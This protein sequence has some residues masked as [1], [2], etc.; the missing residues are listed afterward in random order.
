MICN[1]SKIFT[2]NLVLKMTNDVLG[3]CVIGAFVVGNVVVV[4]V[5]VAGVVVSEVD[6]AMKFLLHEL[7]LQQP[8]T[9]VNRLPNVF[10]GIDEICLQS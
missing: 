5:V 4:V 8:P 7:S 6:K 10:V 2:T 9:N 1:Q 3:S